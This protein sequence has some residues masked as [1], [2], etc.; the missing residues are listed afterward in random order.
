[1][2]ITFIVILCLFQLIFWICDTFGHS[3]IYG[4]LLL[5]R[6]T[7]KQV[8]YFISRS[9][10]MQKFFNLQFTCLFCESVFIFKFQYPSVM[11]PIFT[12]WVMKRILFFAILVLEIEKT[13]IVMD[14][15][16]L[17]SI[18]RID[19]KSHSGKDDSRSQISI[20]WKLDQ[21]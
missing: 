11:L 3:I 18:R 10:S 5:A 17:Y 15:I 2:L 6:G 14:K 4:Q 7:V 16:Q 12:I 9:F 21:I 1:M 13:H 20:C 19:C 8:C